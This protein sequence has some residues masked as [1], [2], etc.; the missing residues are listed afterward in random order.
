MEEASI[1]AN[2]VRQGL[3]FPVESQTLG[4]NRRA[5]SDPPLT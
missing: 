3:G 1:V 2:L 4:S 5:T